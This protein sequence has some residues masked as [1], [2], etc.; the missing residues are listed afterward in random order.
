M[1]LIILIGVLVVY[2]VIINKYLP[3][4]WHLLFALSLSVGLIWWVVN[5]SDLTLESLS[6]RI[7]SIVP[8][9]IYGTVAYV[10]ISLAIASTI[11]IPA[12]KGFLNDKRV[13][14]LSTRQFLYKT[15]VNLPIGTVFLEEV[16]FRGVMLALLMQEFSTLNSV[17]ISSLLFGLWHIIPAYTSVVTNDALNKMKKPAIPVVAGT[18][19]ITFL[20]G[21]GFSWLR[22]AS[23]S[24]IAPMMAHFATN[25][26]GLIASWWTHKFKKS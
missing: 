15:L 5:F 1:D 25:S 20:A 13:I 16:V 24:L 23:G 6:T 7:G 18:V 17:L 3:Q 10:I 26:G 9:L 2:N 11:F 4:K 12:A 21:I 14:R 22:L 19:F 8:G